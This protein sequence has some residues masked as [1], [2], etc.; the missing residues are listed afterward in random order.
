MITTI[1]TCVVPLR[2]TRDVWWS[3]NGGPL[4]IQVEVCD[5]VTKEHIFSPHITS[6]KRAYQRKRAKT[7]S[8]FKGFA[9]GN[10]AT[11]TAATANVKRAPSAAQPSAPP[12]TSNSSQ[13]PASPSGLFSA[14]GKPYAGPKFG[15]VSSSD[16]RESKDDD[17]L[18]TE[19]EADD[20]DEDSET[21]VDDYEDS[22]TEVDDYED[23]ET[24]VD[25][26]E[27]SETEVDSI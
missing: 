9:F 1:L 21:E 18:E 23:S 14:T 11:P 17:D 27:D 24:E 13:A 20:D 25:D 16:N 6:L 4:G 2:S 15:L 10:H 7:S 19:A 12:K 22:E 3:R 8:P 5:P 26:Y